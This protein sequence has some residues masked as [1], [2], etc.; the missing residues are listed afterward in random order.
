[1]SRNSQECS[2]ENL[3]FILKKVNLTGKKINSEHL[4]CIKL[5]FKNLTDSSYMKLYAV[6][7]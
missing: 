7:Q 5:F 6:Q 4:L 1:M 2:F 3:K